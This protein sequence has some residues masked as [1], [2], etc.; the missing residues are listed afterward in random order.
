M[1]AAVRLAQPAW[2][3]IEPGVA[4]RAMATPAADLAS[5]AWDERY[6]HLRTEPEF[7]GAVRRIVSG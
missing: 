6:G 2:G 4:E 1:R 7:D 5:G 3:F